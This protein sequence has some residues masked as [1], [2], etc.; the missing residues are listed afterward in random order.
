MLALE[1]NMDDALKARFVEGYE[2][3]A[4]NLISMGIS[5]DKI[6]EATKLS[7]ERIEEL[8]NHN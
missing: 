8:A 3:V 1:W 4:L 6:H 2:S 5:F 7:I